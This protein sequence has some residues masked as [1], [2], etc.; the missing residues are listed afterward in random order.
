M[1][2]KSI[3]SRFTQLVVGSLLFFAVSATTNATVIYNWVCDSADCN[4]DIGFASSIV[5]TDSAFAAGDFTGIVGN[6]L[7]WDTVSSVG[8]GFALSLDDILSGSPGSNIDDDDNLRIVLSLDKLEISFLEDISAGTNI[9][10]DDPL[11]GRVDFFEGAN[12]SVGSLRDGPLLSDF[13]DIIIQGRFVQSVPE[14]SVALL[15]VAGLLGLL[16]VGKLKAL[17]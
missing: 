11:E 16:G 2:I 17:T 3:F 15:M 6:V 14:P 7:S 4:G 8:D 5:I 12:Y 13:S 1:N 10:F 9:T